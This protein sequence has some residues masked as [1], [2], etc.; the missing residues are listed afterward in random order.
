[1]G[2]AKRRKAAG[3]YPVHAVWRAENEEG[4]EFLKNATQET[5]DGLLQGCIRTGGGSGR[6]LQGPGGEI[7]HYCPEDPEA[8]SPIGALYAALR[9]AYEHPAELPDWLTLMVLEEPWRLAAFGYR[10][11]YRHQIE[12]LHDLFPGIPITAD[13]TWSRCEQEAY[14]YIARR[15]SAVLERAATPTASTKRLAGRRL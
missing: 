9:R 12:N 2:E 11:I 8:D 5:L 10:E 3:T 6:I 14:A 13:Q 7:F 15:E 1:M 4:Q